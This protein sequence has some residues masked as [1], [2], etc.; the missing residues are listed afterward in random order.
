MLLPILKL[1][2]TY[3]FAESNCFEARGANQSQDL[4]L[5]EFSGFYTHAGHRIPVFQLFCPIAEEASIPNQAILILDQE[6]L[7]WLIQYSPATADEPYQIEQHFAFSIQAFAEDEALMTEFL[8][9]PPDWLLAAG[10]QI[11]QRT[12]LEGRVLIA[13]YEKFHLEIDSEFSGVLIPLMSRD[14]D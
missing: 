9:N 3:T 14:I 2:I 1:H 11:E 5:A 12:H 13:S 8:Q 10:S 7:G 6:Q 4:N